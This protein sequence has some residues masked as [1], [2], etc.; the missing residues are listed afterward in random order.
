MRRVCVLLGG[1]WLLVASVGAQPG[2]DSI[3]P[4]LQVGSDPSDTASQRALI[5]TY[6][7][8][9]H[10]DRSRTGGLALDT[11]DVAR[12]SEDAETWEKVVRKLR[13]GM[14]PPFH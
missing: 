1:L 12:L 11:I 5:T 2:P 13:G 3:R 7:I 4:G 8:T 6:C 10:N 14:M 9:C